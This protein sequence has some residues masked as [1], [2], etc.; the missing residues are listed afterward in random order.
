MKN[1]T[2]TKEWRGRQVVGTA[3]ENIAE[4]AHCMEIAFEDHDWTRLELLVKATQH[5]LDKLK[6]F[7][8]TSVYSE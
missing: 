3:V 8:H 6:P 7:C 1:L 2:P 4:N 5:H